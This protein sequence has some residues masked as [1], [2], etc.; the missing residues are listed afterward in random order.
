MKISENELRKIVK[1]IIA[2]SSQWW[3]SEWEFTESDDSA[4]D[5]KDYDLEET[6]NECGY[7]E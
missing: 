4:E 2:E 3:G 1:R 6:Q 5:L 7:S